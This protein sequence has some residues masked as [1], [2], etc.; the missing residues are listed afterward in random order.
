MRRM[1]ENKNHLRERTISLNNIK[2]LADGD[3]EYEQEL[4]ELY[5]QFL[6]DLK[7]NYQELMEAKELE[8]LKAMAHKAK[9]SIVLLD[10]N[11]LEEEMNYGKS[12]LM[13]EKS[14]KRFMKE[15]VQRMLE[16]CDYFLGLLEEYII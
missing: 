5:I 16:D 8:K 3:P 4:K 11:S 12:L 13:I 6:K 9:P 14:E 1:Q 2:E 10:L 15:S 7:Q